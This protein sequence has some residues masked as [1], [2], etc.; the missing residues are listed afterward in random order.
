MFD[1]VYE[2]LSI[3][4]KSERALAKEGIHSQGKWV[5]HARH[6]G[7]AGQT[8]YLETYMALIMTIGHFILLFVSVV[9]LITV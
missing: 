2:M 4:T 6:V 9:T 5:A 3:Y 8:V 7:T 1:K